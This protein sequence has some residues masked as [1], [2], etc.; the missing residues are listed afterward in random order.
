[1]SQIEKKK[2]LSLS[3]ILLT[4]MNCLIRALLVTLLCFPFLR[5]TVFTFV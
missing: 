3:I 1:M 2:V 4:K 5:L